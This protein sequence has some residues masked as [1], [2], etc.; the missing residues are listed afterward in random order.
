MDIDANAAMV[1]CGNGAS[2]SEYE[3]I[4]DN[5]P[6]LGNIGV[7]ITEDKTNDKSSSSA[8]THVVEGSEEDPEKDK[9]ADHRKGELTSIKTKDGANNFE[10]PLF[11][12]SKDLRADAA[13]EAENESM[14]IDIY[15]DIDTSTVQGIFD[16]NENL[17]CD[18]SGKVSLAS[19]EG[20]GLVRSVITVDGTGSQKQTDDIDS[21][22]DSNENNQPLNLKTSSDSLHESSERQ[23]LERRH[24]NAA[25]RQSGIGPVVDSLINNEPST[26]S[27]SELLCKASSG[28]ER[29]FQDRKK[30]TNSDRQSVKILLQVKDRDK[31]IE[32][33]D[34]SN[35]LTKATD[36]SN[37]PNQATTDQSNKPT[38]ITGQSNE[39]TDQSNEPN[40]TKIEVIESKV[41]E[42]IIEDSSSGTI[43]ETEV[44]ESEGKRVMEFSGSSDLP[45]TEVGKLQTK[46]ASLDESKVAI[47]ITKDVLEISHHRGN[48]KNKINNDSGTKYVSDAKE[49]TQCQF[50]FHSIAGRLNSLKK[51]RRQGKLISRL[52]SR[53]QKS[54]VKNVTPLFETPGMK[55][56]LSSSETEAS[57]V[58][59]PSSFVSTEQSKKVLP[60]LELMELT[61]AKSGINEKV[62]LPMELAETKPMQ[63]PRKD[64]IGFITSER[65]SCDAN[66]RISLEGSCK[67]TTI[68]ETKTRVK[69]STGSVWDKSLDMN[70]S[71]PLEDSYEAANTLLLLATSRPGSPGSDTEMK[72][73]NVKE[74][75]IKELDETRKIPSLPATWQQKDD[76]SMQEQPGVDNTG[77]LGGV[78]EVKRD[79]VRKSGIEKWDSQSIVKPL[80]GKQSKVGFS[81]D[82]QLGV[83]LNSSETRNATKGR[84]VVSE[85]EQHDSSKTQE[86]PKK[87]HKNEFSM[88][89]QPGV[90]L[91]DKTRNETEIEQESC[92][93][94]KCVDSKTLGSHT[95]TKSIS[96]HSED[97]GL[98]KT[99]LC[100]E[101]NSPKTSATIRC[102]L[103]KTDK[104]PI[105][106]DKTDTCLN[107][108]L[109]A[110][111]AKGIVTRH[112][113]TDLSNSDSVKTGCVSNSDLD[114]LDDKIVTRNTK[115]NS[116]NSVTCSKTDPDDDDIYKDINIDSL[117][118]AFDFDTNSQQHTENTV[119]SLI[120]FTH[121]LDKNCPVSS[122]ESVAVEIG[123]EGN[124]HDVTKGV[125]VEI[126]KEGNHHDV[127]KG[128]AVEIKKEGNHHDLT[129]N[130]IDKNL[131]TEEKQCSTI[132]EENQL[133][134]GEVLD[135]E[136]E[137]HDGDVDVK[138]VTKSSTN[139]KETKKNE[140]D[141][142]ERSTTTKSKSA[143]T[144][145]S[146]HKLEGEFDI[147]QKLMRSRNESTHQQTPSQDIKGKLN[148]ELVKIENLKALFVVWKLFYADLLTYLDSQFFSNRQ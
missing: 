69:D 138:H 81:I 116:E 55:S 29:L 109:A 143:S 33:T 65:K 51:P 104:N 11:N 20:H 90:S 115:S 30:S 76:F 129:K 59:K 43:T 47:S 12:N 7:S 28:M 102:Q 111:A 95:K 77:S 24:F 40:K 37:K 88:N 3:G 9:S 91:D 22:F 148:N 38:E 53:F 141:A 54:D 62:E 103:D 128:V 56:E 107:M 61:D 26:S 39:P 23:G 52:E 45:E 17:S 119:T 49:K 121:A 127:T 136:P 140:D 75:E 130:Q 60:S 84:I 144:R 106:S 2:K 92:S 74:Q 25:Q 99:D 126:E 123:K 132:D 50:F 35:E 67:R 125:A 98:Q 79:I 120:S 78:I 72:S 19:P 80:K 32:T 124:H 137:S 13:T 113:K 101:T 68:S 14:D 31:N 110:S 118:G 6:M 133:E 46:H 57:P 134:E 122:S 97:I 86:E 63:T 142:K 82:E 64:D 117:Y 48:L 135:S 34:Q 44:T 4:G 10:P 58:K 42:H 41:R 1:G 5:P 87:T 70:E 85:M 16:L 89:E 66:E 96:H 112:T 94:K 71:N 105:K 100:Q 114:D 93:V 73:E 21:V 139:H 145:G 146:T 27:R 18:L 83:N 108:D 36:Q 147:R 8:G 15:S 131:D